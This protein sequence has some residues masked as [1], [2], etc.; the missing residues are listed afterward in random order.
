MSSEDSFIKISGHMIKGIMF[1]DQMTTYYD[2]LGFDGFKKEQEYHFFDEILSYKRLKGYF[3]SHYNK[4]I[5]DKQL[6]NPE[7]VPA[8]WYGHKRQDVDASTK[9]NAVREGFRKWVSWEM[10]TK[11]LYE[12]AVSDMYAEG[13]IAAAIVFEKLVADVDQELSVAEEE[14][15]KIDSSSYEL[16]PLMEM[17]D[18]FLK[19]YS[20]KLNSLK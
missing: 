20:C 7:A 2:F 11:K 6:E 4:L 13:S 5:E 9:R 3:L 10:D 19:K 12:K 15:L 8:D 16:M 18:S 17:Q 14:K 1:H